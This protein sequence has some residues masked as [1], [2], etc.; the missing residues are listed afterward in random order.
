MKKY[1]IHDGTNQLGPFDLDELVSKNLHADTPIWYEGLPDW[2]TAGKL[3][4][5]KDII[6]HTPPPFH[7][8][9]QP[10][11]EEVKP[12][13]ENMQTPVVVAPVTT[14]VQAE[15]KPT[16][17]KQETPA[18][19]A[20]QVAAIPVIPAA[21]PIAKS[22][23]WISMV[24][25]LVLLAGTAFYVYWDMTHR[26]NNNNSSILTNPENNSLN[27]PVITNPDSTAGWI[28]S[29]KSLLNKQLNQSNIDTAVMNMFTNDSTQNRP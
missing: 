23:A 19:A 16:E 15:I 2:T 13:E 5:L 20:T 14:A 17:I 21:K 1:F 6:V 4:E 8:S 9:P 3:D 27:N 26:N 11:A 12:A 7:A 24:A 22:T 10:V 28:D 29:L 25:G 18:P